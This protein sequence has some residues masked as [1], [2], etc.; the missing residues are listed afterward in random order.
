MQDPSRLLPPQLKVISASGC[1]L[2]GPDFGTSTSRFMGEAVIATAE[3]PTFATESDGVNIMLLRGAA[4]G[5]W[6]SMLFL[7]NFE[8]TSYVD[9]I[10]F[11]F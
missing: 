10:D 4:Q 9:L 3:G 2:Q 7:C 6:H 11:F 5:P 1:G 8:L